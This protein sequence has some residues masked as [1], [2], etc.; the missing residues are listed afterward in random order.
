M[1]K[2]A[3]AVHWPHARDTAYEERR[4]TGAAMDPLQRP[5]WRR[6]LG[7]RVLVF[8]FAVGWWLAST[9]QWVNGGDAVPVPDSVTQAR[10]MVMVM[11]F[12]ALLFA[13]AFA[14]H[15]VIV[16]LIPRG[17]LR[18]FLLLGVDEPH[19]RRALTASDGLVRKLL[20]VP[21]FLSLGLLCAGFA[22]LM[23]LCGTGA[24]C[25]SI[26]ASFGPGRLM[27]MVTI[28]SLAAILLKH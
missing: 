27:A 10:T 1:S 19:A 21:A 3:I 16:S 2:L 20:I 14:I 4:R 28:T 13:A 22:A 18:S 26:V 24:V 7:L 9:L 11:C 23:A 12:T 25:E 6:L 15:D 5:L 17:P 8:I